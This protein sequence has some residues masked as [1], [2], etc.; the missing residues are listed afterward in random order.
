MPINTDFKALIHTPIMIINKGFNNKGGKKKRKNG[1][2]FEPV[3]GC[4]QR[5]QVAGKEHCFTSNSQTYVSIISLHILQ[6]SN[7]S[8]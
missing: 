3:A 7:A 1:S 5:V 8:L 6:V 2:D 4:K